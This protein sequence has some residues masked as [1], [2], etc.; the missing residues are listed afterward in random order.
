MSSLAKSTAVESR[1]PDFT[2]GQ[3]NKAY[4]LI[5]LVKIYNITNCTGH[6]TKDQIS[7]Q[8]TNVD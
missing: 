2:S 5:G 4:I 3:I 7:S 8:L 6:I 1:H